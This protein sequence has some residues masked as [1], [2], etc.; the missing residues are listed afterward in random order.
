[1]A[2]QA[3]LK[4]LSIET[5]FDPCYLSL[6]STFNGAF[7]WG[8]WGALYFFGPKMAP[9]LTRDHLKGLKKSLAPQKLLERPHYLFFLHKKE[10]IPH[11]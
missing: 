5:N 10:N 8:F 1:M 4:Y 11:L 3:V 9:R 6:D 2:D 7:S